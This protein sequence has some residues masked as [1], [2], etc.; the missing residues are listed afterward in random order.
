MRGSQRDLLKGDSSLTEI[1]HTYGFADYAHYSRVF[2]RVVGTSPSVW[3]TWAARSAE[4]AEGLEGR[5]TRAEDFSGA[6]STA[7]IRRS[8]KAI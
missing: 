1:A 7:A 2:K 4:A 8:T 6:D 3:R 5:I